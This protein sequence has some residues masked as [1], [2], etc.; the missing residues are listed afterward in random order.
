[1]TIFGPK[2]LKIIVKLNRSRVRTPVRS[3]ISRGRMAKW[4]NAP[5]SD[6]TCAA[7]FLLLIVCCSVCVFFAIFYHTKK[8]STN[9]A[10][11]NKHIGERERE[12]K[13]KGLLSLRDRT[14]TCERQ[15]HPRCC[16]RWCDA[17]PLLLLLLAVVVLVERK[18][19]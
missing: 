3:N 9:L 17:P 18:Q 15:H 12:K 1:M 2:H 4:M 10:R 11:I 7:I 13:H 16:C 19:L 8:V 14:T 6:Q 5:V